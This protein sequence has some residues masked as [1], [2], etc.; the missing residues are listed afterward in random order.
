MSDKKIQNS[1]DSWNKKDS[2]SCYKKKWNKWAGLALGIIFCGFAVMRLHH[3]SVG[4]QLWWLSLVPLV[5][6]VP[7]SVWLNKKERKPWAAFL[8]VF[9]TCG[10]LYLAAVPMLQVSDETLHYLRSYEIAAGQ[11]PRSVVVDG[12]KTVGDTMTANLIPEEL[13]DFKK[14]SYE[15]IR[16]AWEERT[17]DDAAESY[18]FP[19]SALYSPFTYL[20]QAAGILIAR[21]VTNRSLS[22]MYAGR[23]SN[24]IIVGMLAALALRLFPFAENL[25]LL[26]LLLP[27]FVHKSGSMSA[28]GLTL[29]VIFLLLSYILH[30]QYGTSGTWTW[31]DIAPLYPL[32]FMVSQC[33]V[34]YLPVCLTFF[35]LSPGRFRSRKRYFLHLLC[36]VLLA[37][38]GSLGWLAISSSYLEEGYS[39]SGGQIAFILS[40]PMDYLTILLRTGKKQGR[41]LLEQLMGI[42]MGVGG[43]RNSAILCYVY[44]LLI[45]FTA[46]FVQR[47]SKAIIRKQGSES[48][49]QKQGGAATAQKRDS[50]LCL[51][52]ALCLVLLTCTALFVQWTAPGEKVIVGLQGRYFIPVLYLLAIAVM[53]IEPLERHIRKPRSYHL[54]LLIAFGINL[55]SVVSCFAYGSTL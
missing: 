6:L 25:P 14:T 51:F 52:S 47:S 10:L 53:Q 44:L 9:Y 12:E 31:K 43:V 7:F 45:L 50:L 8:I 30:L 33:K 19:G 49:D 41:N 46:L 36:L 55:I 40:R 4:R 27:M 18:A 48:S 17:D 32:V 16:A 5:G 34:V 28:D 20:P 24:L 29:A 21:H 22:L 15:D 39:A 42:G 1:R 35:I 26:L 38:G 2:N 11:S 54:S 13:V 37:V 3:Y 23:L